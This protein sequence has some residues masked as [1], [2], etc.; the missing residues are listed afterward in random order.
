MPRAA[1][2][3]PDPEATQAYRRAEH[4]LLRSKLAKSGSCSTI[5]SPHP[6][7]C[8]VLARAMKEE[9]RVGT[10]LARPETDHR[11]ISRCSPRS[12]KHP[13]ASA[14]PHARTTTLLPRQGSLESVSVAQ[15]VSTSP[16]MGHAVRD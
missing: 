12:R 4:M 2:C 14:L 8:G 3:E 11:S 9:P 16:Q 7:A 10:R 15:L 1:T 6:L 5:Q 13:P